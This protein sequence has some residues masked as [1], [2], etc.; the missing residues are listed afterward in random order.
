M[1]GCLLADFGADVIKVEMPEG[2]VARRLPPL[3][4][5]TNPP[6]SFMHVTGNRN[7]RS[8]TLDLRQPDGAALFRKLAGTADIVVENFR[9]GTMQGWGLGYEQLR[10]VKPELIYVVWSRRDYDLG[11]GRRADDA[12]RELLGQLR[13]AGIEVIEQ[14]S[15]YSPGWGGWRGQDDEILAALFPLAPSE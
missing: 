13:D 6:L 5:G 7:K 8:L 14:I 15:D 12:S 2:E 11:G 4:P 10:E 1:C 3:L 9:P